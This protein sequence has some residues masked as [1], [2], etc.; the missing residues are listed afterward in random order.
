MKTL[1]VTGGNIEKEL[2]L[3]TIN[4]TKYKI[5]INLKHF[6]NICGMM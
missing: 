6:E 2:L 5:P 4:E 1:I 3:K